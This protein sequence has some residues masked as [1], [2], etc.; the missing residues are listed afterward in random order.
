MVRSIRKE[1]I[2]LSKC[3]HCGELEQFFYKAIIKKC[4]SCKKVFPLKENVI[5]EV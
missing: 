4:S 5:H 1:V 3:P 2:V